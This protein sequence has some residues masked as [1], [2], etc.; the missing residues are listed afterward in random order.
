MLKR[1]DLADADAIVQFESA[2]RNDKFYGKPLD[3]AA[4]QS[5]IKANDYYLILTHGRIV[6]TGALRTRDD[7][8]A[9][10]SNIA[11]HPEMRRQGLARGMMVHLLSCCDDARSIDLAVHPDNRPALTLYTSLNFAP[12]RC[13]E[14]YF[15]DGE[16]RLIMSR[17]PATS[18][19]S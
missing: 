8:R 12:M 4:T 19:I 6:A 3:H 14:N 1:A 2:V 5:E 13:Q 10:L 15:G 11:V 9:Y 16:P 18:P 7:G 17:P